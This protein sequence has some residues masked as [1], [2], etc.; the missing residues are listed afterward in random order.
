MGTPD[1]MAPEQADD[2]QRVDTRSDLY[3]LGCTFYYILTANLPF[4]GGN[5]LE[6][7]LRHRTE[8]PP[9]PSKLRREIPAKVDAILRKLMAKRPEDRYQKPAELA[10][11]LG[12]M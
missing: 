9:A 4:P 5:R 3:S 7:L 11:A 6:K 1:F 10:E 8:E 2:A 12:K